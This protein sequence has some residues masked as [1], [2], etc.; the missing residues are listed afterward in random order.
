[1]SSIEGRLD[2]ETQVKLMSRKTVRKHEQE[3]SYREDKGRQDYQNKTGSTKTM[4]HDNLFKMD[5]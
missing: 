1:M 2:N 3:V 5:L 4:H